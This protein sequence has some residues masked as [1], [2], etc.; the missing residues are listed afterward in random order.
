MLL[1][2]P[3]SFFA[4]AFLRVLRVLSELGWRF[5]GILRA[6]FE[7]QSLGRLSFAVEGITATNSS[8]PTSNPAKLEKFM[9]PS[10][11]LL[12]VE[13]AIISQRGLWT[14]VFLL[15]NLESQPHKVPWQRKFN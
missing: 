6:M 15:F 10:F 2:M 4:S 14:T 1:R 7:I 9:P 13:V 12:L 5:P 3:P 11:L 8:H